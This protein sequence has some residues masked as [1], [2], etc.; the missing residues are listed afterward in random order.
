MANWSSHDYPK[1]FFY[2][3]DKSSGKNSSD[4]SGCFKSLAN[5]IMYGI[6][7]FIILYYLFGK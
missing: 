6:I 7:A 4:K 5:L 2:K 3:N 1:N